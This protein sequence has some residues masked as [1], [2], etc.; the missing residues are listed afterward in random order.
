NDGENQLKAVGSKGGVQ[1]TDDLQF[2]YQTQRWDRPARLVLEELGR[3]ADTVVLQALALDSSGILC[4]GAQNFVRFGLA[5][6]GRLIDNLGTS[7]GS[8]KIQLYNGRAT[9]RV[10]LNNGNSVVSVSSAGV[11]TAFVTLIGTPSLPKR[12]S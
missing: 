9:I 8:R 6:D 2:R 7:T 12:N 5:G 11:P 4:L 10:K 1:V 3:E